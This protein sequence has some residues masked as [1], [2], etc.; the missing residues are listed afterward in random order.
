MNQIPARALAGVAGGYVLA[1]WLP[2][3]LME[4]LPL[5]RVDTVALALLMSFAVYVA[6]ILWCFA[7][8]SAWRACAGLA[9][10]GLPCGALL[11]A[12]GRWA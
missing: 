3:A 4:A 12:L 8:R 6:A 9:L 1:Q 2:L 10:V 5:D 11:L 7:A